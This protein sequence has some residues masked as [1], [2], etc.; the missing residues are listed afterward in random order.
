MTTRLGRYGKPMQ[1][2]VNVSARQLAE[3]SSFV[4]LVEQTL[5]R[6]SLSPAS[7]LLEVTESALMEDAEA[8]VLVLADLKG[9]GVMIAIDDFGT[10]YS[11]LSYLQRFPVDHLKIDMSF[12]ARLDQRTE[13][14]M[15]V[16]SVIEL[17]RAVGIEAV[18]EGVETRE[19]LAALRR[20]GCIF[21]QG[22]L[23]SRSLPPVDLET[24]VTTERPDTSHP[25]SLPRPIRSAATS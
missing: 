11:S 20:L 22:F 10:G 3:G 13:N 16:R 17:T 21:G 15:I 7:L 4:E 25:F 23:W 1:V 6:H 9:L 2:A 8:A 5:A 12:V 18:A 19:Q 14:D 24:Y